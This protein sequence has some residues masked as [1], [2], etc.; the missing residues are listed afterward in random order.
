M[1]AGTADRQEKVVDKTR[2]GYAYGVRR[3]IIPGDT[4][5]RCN[6]AFLGAHGKWTAGRQLELYGS[7]RIAEDDNMADLW[8]S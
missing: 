3:E 8:R 5:C 6:K 2:S 4:V 1:H 7:L